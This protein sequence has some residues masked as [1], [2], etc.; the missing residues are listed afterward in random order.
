[1]KISRGHARFAKKSAQARYSRRRCSWSTV[2]L[3]GMARCRGIRPLA[4][5]GARCALIHACTNYF[6][7]VVDAVSR[8]KTLIS[9]VL[10][11]ENGFTELN[12]HS[13]SSQNALQAAKELLD[14]AC[15]PENQTALQ[16]TY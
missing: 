13:Q 8:L 1:M 6:T 12:T 7:I 4:S 15:R 2:Q 5:T 16:C 10:L 9:S 11:P 3:L 14:W